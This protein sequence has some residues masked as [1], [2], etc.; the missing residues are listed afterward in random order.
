[1]DYLLRDS[2]H[3]GVAY[4]RFDHFRLIDTLRILPHA[5]ADT[6]AHQGESQD[7]TNEGEDSSDDGETKR[8]PMLGVEEGGLQS[9]EA[10]ML[11]RYFIYSQVCFHHI[12][13]IY[14]IHL[15]DFLQEWLPGDA[16]STDIET[17]LAQTDNEITSA[18]WSAA[19]NKSDQS[20][21][22]ARRIV[23]RQH[24]KTVYQRQP[25]DVGINRKAGQSVYK[26]AVQT[27]GQDAVRHD[28]YVEEGGAPDF[29]VKRRDGQI[30]SSLALSQVPSKFTRFIHRLCICREKHR[31]QI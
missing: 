30:V 22:A 15:R 13:R 18:L 5:P 19:F 14:D 25:Q 29:P 7:H 1:M 11:A 17:H 28:Y 9:A 31:A 16:F 10:L 27:F 8:E 4:G 23:R 6:Q 2:L 20:H 21:E 24:Y 12:R 26:A 3:T